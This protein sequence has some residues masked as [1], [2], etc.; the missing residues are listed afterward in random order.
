MTSE[1]D[2]NLWMMQN[3]GGFNLPLLKGCF[4]NPQ[5]NSDLLKTVKD[6][7][8]FHVFESTFMLR[9]KLE[10]GVCLS[11]KPIKADKTL[12]LL[13]WRNWKQSKNPVDSKPI[14]VGD[15]DEIGITFYINGNFCII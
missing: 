1:L 5:T 4:S 3:L 10:P 2:E 14:F 15:F 13:M 8:N 11:A 9:G 6:L 7:P 12:D